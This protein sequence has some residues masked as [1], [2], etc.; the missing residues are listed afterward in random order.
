MPR[1]Q[2]LAEHYASKNVQ[3][4]AIS[5][6]APDS[7]GRIDDVVRKRNFRL[8]VWTGADEKML[9]ALKLGELVP[10]TLILDENGE[11]IGKIEGE[12]RDNDVRTRVDW[13]LG[14]RVGKQPKLVQKNDW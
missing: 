10:A 9:T 3:F 13:L 11:T 7:Q 8:P 2:K 12:A 1:L 5:I 4:I 14:G 6:D